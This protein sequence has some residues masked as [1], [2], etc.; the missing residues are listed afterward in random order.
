MNCEKRAA[1]GASLAIYENRSGPEHLLVLGAHFP[2][3]PESLRTNICL[4]T[5]KGGKVEFGKRVSL[6]CGTCPV[7]M[8]TNDWASSGRGRCGVHPSLWRRFFSQSRESSAIQSS[9]L[10]SVLKP[11]MCSSCPFG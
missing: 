1:S 8:S 10:A 11:V 6:K 3:K 4:A 2:S 9:A 5:L 7:A